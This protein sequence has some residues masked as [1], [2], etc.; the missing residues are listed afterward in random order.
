M[1]CSIGDDEERTEMVEMY[2]S[3]DNLNPRRG[4][5]SSSYKALR[6]PPPA[7]KAA[8]LRML[9]PKA[10]KPKSSEVYMKHNVI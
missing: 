5:E 2:V 8:K 6:I 4:R 3:V 10:S 9:Q 7:V 1:T